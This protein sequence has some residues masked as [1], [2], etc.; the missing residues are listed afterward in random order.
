MLE[1]PLERNESVGIATARKALRCAC[2]LS[3]DLLGGPLL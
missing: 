1:D 2:S 3:D